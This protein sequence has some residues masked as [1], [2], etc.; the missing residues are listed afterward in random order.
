MGK[1]AKKMH[2]SRAPSVALGTFTR[3]EAAGHVTSGIRHVHCSELGEKDPVYVATVSA[4]T[5]SAI[6]KYLWEPTVFVQELIVRGSLER[7]SVLEQ[8]I[9]NSK[10]DV[11]RNLRERLELVVEELLTN[12]LFHAFRSAG[13]EKYSRK[14]D[15]QLSSLEAVKV[16][17]AATEDGCFI[18]VQDNGGSLTFDNI[19]ESL[20]RCYESESQI[21]AKESGAG[22]GIYMIF[23]TAS[24]LKVVNSPGNKTVISCWI[25][26]HRSEN[27]RNFSFNYFEGRKS[28]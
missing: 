3:R 6:P 7:H 4:L 24:H 28:K 22:L 5:K 15:V 16:R 25:A 27:P 26:D 19:S 2:A 13:K 10:V 1:P 11:K 12:A 9:K 14:E 23:E 21:Q 20:K 8:L 17:F 18:E